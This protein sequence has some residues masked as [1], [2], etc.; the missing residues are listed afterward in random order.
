MY[1]ISRLN[2]ILTL[3]IGEKKFL[4]ISKHIWRSQRRKG[5]E[6]ASAFSISYILGKGQGIKIQK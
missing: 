5:I 3:L 4:Y 6:T 2:F 1:L